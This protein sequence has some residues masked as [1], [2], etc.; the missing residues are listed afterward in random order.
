[1]YIPGFVEHIDI[2]AFLHTK[3]SNI[4]IE[5]GNSNFHVAGSFLLNYAK[6]SLLRFFGRDPRVMIDQSIGIIGPLCFFRSTTLLALSF[7]PDSRLRRI[8]QSA[9][10]ECESLRWITIPASVEIL[11]E[12]CFSSC[13]SLLRISFQSHSQLR[14]IECGAFS[15]CRSLQSICIPAS[16]EILRTSCFCNCGSLSAVSFESG[17]RLSEIGE[18]VFFLCFSLKSICIP[19]SVRVLG[20]KCFGHTQ[21][22]RQGCRSLSD[23][24]F[25][26]ESQLV[27]IE[28][29]T[30]EG[31][32]ALRSICI[33]A[34]VELL[35]EACFVS[36]I[37]LSVVSF[38]SGSHLKRI[39][40]RAFEGISVKSIFIPRSVES[41]GSMC[42]AH[43]LCLDELT[44]ECW[45]KLVR[46]GQH[47]FHGCEGLKYIHVQKVDGNSVSIPSNDLKLVV[48][49]IR[50]E[51]LIPFDPD[52][53]TWLSA[54]NY[55]IRRELHSANL[56]SDRLGSVRY[57]RRNSSIHQLPPSAVFSTSA[58]DMSDEDFMLGYDQFLNL[59]C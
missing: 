9:F 31:C 2:S 34:S 27:R 1:L 52:S 8:D 48:R 18:Q 24:I 46:I 50:E 42:F 13:I 4:R 39:E 53:P 43:C 25:E 35:S 3:I 28:A 21:F 7:E 33:P 55:R 19:S 29:M 37:N 22:E 57:R 40:H 12:K 17:S 23:V 44:F 54:G 16:V 6:I 41:I 14:R 45:S 47:A 20:S 56:R 32:S 30:F 38:E 59:N 11:G 58:T 5:D 49:I 36:C 15:G 26:S 51:K 10:D